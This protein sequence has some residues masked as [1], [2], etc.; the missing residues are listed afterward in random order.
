[1]R[2]RIINLVRAACWI[3]VFSAARFGLMKLAFTFVC[4]AGGHNL[5]EASVGAVASVALGASIGIECFLWL[6]ERR[7]G[8]LDDGPQKSL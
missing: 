3:G 8:N 5:L 6:R 7:M 1:M 4:W 2:T